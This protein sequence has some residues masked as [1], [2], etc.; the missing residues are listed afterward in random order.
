MSTLMCKPPEMT[1]TS[2]A[3]GNW[4]CRAFSAS[5]Q[6]FQCAWPE[7][8]AGIHITVKDQMPI[9]MAMALWGGGGGGGGGGRKDHPVLH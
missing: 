3:S 9:V 7:S 6:L 4:G 8:W 2:D 5:G 1:L